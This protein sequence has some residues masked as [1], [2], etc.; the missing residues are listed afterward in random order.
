MQTWK[1]LVEKYAFS[2]FFGILISFSY[3]K[4]SS[5]YQDLG[6]QKKYLSDNGIC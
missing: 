5:L 6:N 4:Y 1:G 2:N 3:T